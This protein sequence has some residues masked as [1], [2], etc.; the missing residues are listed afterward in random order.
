MSPKVFRGMVCF[1]LFLFIC[2]GPAVEALVIA[3]VPL[4]DRIEKIF[5]TVGR[6]RLRLHFE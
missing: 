5:W 4:F 3:F 6:T 1:A 2:C